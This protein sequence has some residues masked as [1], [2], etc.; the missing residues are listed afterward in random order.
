MPHC[1]NKPYIEHIQFAHEQIQEV[2]KRNVL[3]V[4]YKTHRSFW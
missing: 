1:V 4:D 2:Y 3:S